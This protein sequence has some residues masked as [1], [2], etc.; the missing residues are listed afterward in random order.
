MVD[1]R[2]AIIAAGNAYSERLD[3]SYTPLAEELRLRFLDHAEPT[4]W[5]KDFKVYPFDAAN[6]RAESP[7]G[8]C[9]ADHPPHVLPNSMTPVITF[10]PFRMSGAILALTSLDFLGLGVPASVPSWR[11]ATAGQAPRCLVDHRATFVLLRSRC[12]AD[13]HRRR[14]ARCL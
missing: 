13:L 11:S 4:A 3:P 12:C 6:S 7:R 5:S 2:E 14:A 1:A 8:R 10:L 9:A